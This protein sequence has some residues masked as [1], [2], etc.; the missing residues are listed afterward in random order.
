[1]DMIQLGP[2]DLQVGGVLPWPVFDSQERLLLKQGAV[3]GSPRQLE[4][5]LLRGVYRSSTEEGGRRP[6]AEAREV[7]DNS[8]P[9]E[10][11][12]GMIRRV[13]GLLDNVLEAREGAAERIG[14]FADEL[15]ALYKEAPH[16]LIGAVHL[17]HEYEY[18]QIHPVHVAILCR[19]MAGAQGYADDDMRSLLAAALTQNVAMLK[20]QDELQYHQ[21]PLSDEQRQQITAHPARAVQLLRAA[22]VKDRRWLAAVMQHHERMD[23]RGYPLGISGNALGLDAKLIALGDRYAAMVSSRAYRAARESREALKDFFLHKGEFCEEALTLAFIREIGVY[24]P[25]S[26][27]LLSNGEAGV[28]IRKGKEAIRPVVSAYVSPR[29]APYARPFRRDC[30]VGDYQVRNTIKPDVSIPINLSTLWAV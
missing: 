6:A 5:L 19:M 21:G 17:V 10:R 2:G 11:L 16:A 25:G 9:F 4:S 8:T 1:M 28:V 24:P 26:F 12:D 13:P 27:V 7:P 30:A 20:L 18:S 14:R 15:D 23:G 22:G 3:I 29:G